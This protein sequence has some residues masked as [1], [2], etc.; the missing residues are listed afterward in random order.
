M[1]I[2]SYSYQDI[3]LLLGEHVIIGDVNQIKIT[4]LENIDTNKEN[5]ICFID[6]NRKDK[7]ELLDKTLAKVVVIDDKELKK[8]YLTK[9]LIQVKD[10]KLTISFVGNNL[11]TLKMPLG[12]IHESAVIHPEAIIDKL[13]F[14]GPNCTIGKVKI[15]SNSIIRSNVTLFDNV[16]IGSG[17][18]ISS[19]SVIGSEGY[20]Y[21]RDQDGKLIQFPHIGRVII[22]NNVSIGTNVSID[23]GALSDTVIGK[24]TKIDNLVHIAHNVIIG[25]DCCIVA[26]AV[27]CGSTTIGKKSY[28][29]PSSCVRDAIHI[30][31]NTLIGLSATVMKSVPSN[32]VWVGSPA[33]PLSKYVKNRKKISDL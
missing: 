8:Q 31:E 15:G 27:I 3:K 11:F 16:E 5:A 21:N 17:V 6:K 20:G 32:E 23:R 26:N 4:S 7:E 22:E 28:I 29:A 19:G 14:I 25:E 30:G 10:P 13:V 33:L 1:N 12:I 2:K 9:V 24:G 18:D